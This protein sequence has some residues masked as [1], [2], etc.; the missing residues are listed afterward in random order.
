[1]VEF[2]DGNYYHFITD[3]E[4]YAANRLMYEYR[5]YSGSKGFMEY[6]YLFEQQRALMQ[7][8]LDAMLYYQKPI[9]TMPAEDQAHMF[10]DKIK[11]LRPNEMIMLDTEKNFNDPKSD[12]GDYED[13]ANRWWGV[14]E[15]RLDTLSWVYVPKNISGQL[16][17]R[18]TGQRIVKAPKYSRMSSRGVAPDW[19]H[20]VHQYTDIGW[21]PG[22]NGPGDTNWTDMTVSQML[23]RCRRTRPAPPENAIWNDILREFVGG[24]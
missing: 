2:N 18:V 22:G 15:N 13:F 6:D 8:R 23:D 14:A 24:K 7:P 4:A 5:V 17:R 19:D 10:C 3:P 9:N 16:S 20:D 21:F 1:M 12:L 11:V